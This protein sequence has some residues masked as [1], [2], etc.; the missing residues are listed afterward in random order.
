MANDGGWRGRMSLVNLPNNVDARDE[1]TTDARTSSSTAPTA[2]DTE[3][4]IERLDQ[5]LLGEPAEDKAARL[6]RPL[7]QLAPSPRRWTIK[8]LRHTRSKRVPVV[9]ESLLGA[10]ERPSAEARIEPT[11]TQQPTALRQSMASDLAPEQL[12]SRAQSGAGDAPRLE[13]RCP[14]EEH[15]LHNAADTA[16][17]Q[18]KGAEVP[19]D[20]TEGAVDEVAKLL[21]TEA[22]R[23]ARNQSV[24]GETPIAQTETPFPKGLDALPASPSPV[25]HSGRSA[26]P[27]VSD[28]VDHRPPN[29]VQRARQP[30]PPNGE[31][32][33]D[34]TAALTGVQYPKLPSRRR[35]SQAKTERISEGETRSVSSRVRL[36]G[37]LASI[38]LAL[39]VSSF[40][41]RSVEDAKMA[42]AQAAQQT[43]RIAI[44]RYQADHGA[45]PGALASA[46]A[47]CV[48]EAVPG[49][50]SAVTERAFM[51]QLTQ[52]TNQ[53]GQSCS[54][55]TETFAFGPYLKSA[56]LPDEPF[57]LS[58][59]LVIVS[60]TD[61]SSGAHVPLSGGWLYNLDTGQFVPNR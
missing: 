25:E 51:D 32:R 47:A 61:E 33:H 4:S 38:A 54:L 1:D 17:A 39:V 16:H 45:L 34:L 10:A 5:L 21:V 6:S 2:S 30:I 46:G 7:D 36:L 60:G 53:V 18:L 19:S 28:V 12:A 49:G 50:G 43:M 26:K 41:D 9:D 57:T 29:A 35:N 44:M 3:P 13:S 37:V 58:N 14:F 48:A 23:V 20:A 8:A 55:P 31:S 40:M 27:I 56:A 22:L 11:L 42:A 15:Q 24:K 59:K 52:Y